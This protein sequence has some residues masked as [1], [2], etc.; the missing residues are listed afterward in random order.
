MSEQTTSQPAAERVYERCLCREAIDRF[1]DLFHI[2]SDEARTHL[3]NS[4]VEFLKAI[5]SLIDDRIAHLS[6]ASQQ[7]TKVSVE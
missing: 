3:R 2:R 6:S 5:R 1:E 7:G 4:R